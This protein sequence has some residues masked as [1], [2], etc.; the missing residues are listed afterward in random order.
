M[1]SLPVILSRAPRHGADAFSLPEIMITM[2]ITVIVIGAI[3]ASY[4]YGMRMYQVTKP[5][6]T[7]SEGARNTVSRMVQEIR[8]AGAVAVGTGSGS[9]FTP[10]PMNAAQTGNAIEI[11][12]DQLITNQFVRY[13]VDPNDDMLKR[14]VSGKTNQQVLARNVTNDVP[15]AA[16]DYLGKTL[17][18]AINNQ[19]I[20]VTLQF[21]TIRTPGEKM[22]P[23]KVYDFY[24][25]RT[26][27][28]R[29]N[30]L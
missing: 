24:Q 26:R 18:N 22:G 12:P 25:L 4:M 2:T 13:F 17:T 3:L 9:R 19:V 14:M 29:R 30:V 1:K 6:L 10:A 8:S 20:A 11:Y 16:E 23:S 21:S 27:V 15:F 5:K 7:A 28:T